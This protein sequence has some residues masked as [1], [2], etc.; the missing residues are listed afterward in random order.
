[1]VATTGANALNIGAIDGG[2]SG[3]LVRDL[4]FN[5]VGL[6]NVTGPITDDNGGPIDVVKNNNGKVVFSGT[7]TYHNGTTINA[8]ILQFNSAATALL[9]GGASAGRVVLSGASNDYTGGTTL[10]SNVLAI[11]KGAQL[12]TG[13]LTFSGGTLDVTGAAPFAYAGPAAT[14]TAPSTIQIDN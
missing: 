9:V 3:G 14:I 5:N 13:P 11:D 1:Q 12:G 10:K 4:I 6:V 7:N 8:G 2:S